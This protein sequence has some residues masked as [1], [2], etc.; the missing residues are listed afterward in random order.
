MIVTLKIGIC[1][2]RVFVDVS[3]SHAV[4]S[5]EKKKHANHLTAH[6]KLHIYYY[7]NNTPSSQ[8][9]H[10]HT[11]A[12]LSLFTTYSFS[13]DI[14]LFMQITLFFF[15]PL[16]FFFPLPALSLSLSAIWTWIACHFVLLKSFSLEHLESVSGAVCR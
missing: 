6:I 14:A 16:L 4:K 3:L 15:V 11:R 9:T 2:E 8:E 7:Q 5:F 13:A 10:I 1:A 12:R